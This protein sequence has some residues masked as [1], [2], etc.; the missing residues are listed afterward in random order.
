[1]AEEIEEQLDLSCEKKISYKRNYLRLDHI[2][3]IGS[4]LISTA[5]LYYV[6]NF[7]NEPQDLKLGSAQKTEVG[8]LEVSNENI[9]G[10]PDSYLKIGDNNFE[11]MANGKS[12]DTKKDS[13]DDVVGQINIDSDTDTLVSNVNIDVDDIDSTSED[14]VN[15]LDDSNSGHIDQVA[16]SEAVSITVSSELEAEEYE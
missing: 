9:S 4:V 16:D 2:L 12:G 1:M 3:L 10:G 6:L 5:G 13:E 8:A 15:V 11:L 7:F 14:D